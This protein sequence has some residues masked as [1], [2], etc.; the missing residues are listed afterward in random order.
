LPGTTEL[1]DEVTPQ[2]IKLLKQLRDD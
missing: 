2:S 1:P